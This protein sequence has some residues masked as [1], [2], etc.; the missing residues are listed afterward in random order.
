MTGRQDSGPGAGQPV[1]QRED[2][3]PHREDV[4]AHQRTEVDV[5]AVGRR[6]EALLDEVTA[7]D[8]T[9][10]RVAEELV[11]ELVGLYGAGL[12]R[13]VD[14]LAAISPTALE[15][16][17][18]DPLVAGLLVLH[19][20]HPGAL[21]DR[22]EA[23]LDECRPYLDSHG[24]GVTLVGIDDGTVRLQLEG[25]CDGCGASELTMT[26]AVEA[27]ILVAAPEIVAIDVAGIPAPGEGHAPPPGGPP[28][29]LAGVGAGA[30][31]TPQTL[32]P[33]TL[34]MYPS[35]IRGG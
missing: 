9:L 27:A 34:P 33:Q 30:P 13:L 8:P 25:T 20:L 17:S 5:D 18:T 28:P 4:P 3:A 21:E 1:A 22:I 6:V 2:P 16:L 23:A 12:T 29:P 10:A 19:D 11:A 26:N 35:A 7:T 14:H 24:G 15:E 32:P 31:S